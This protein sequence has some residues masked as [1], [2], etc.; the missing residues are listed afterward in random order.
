M[1]LGEKNKTNRRYHLFTAL[2]VAIFCGVD[3]LT[4]WR[5]FNEFHPVGMI[6]TPLLN[7]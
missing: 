4:K 7:P 5:V 6:I 2:G 1:S 3:L